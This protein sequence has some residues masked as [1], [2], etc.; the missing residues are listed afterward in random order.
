MSVRTV[1]LTLLPTPEQAV[2][3][4]RVGADWV[5]ACNLLSAVAWD[6]KTFRPYDLQK[7]AYYRV[8]SETGLLAQLTVRAV[9]V[10][11]DSYRRDRTRRHVFHARAALVLDTPRLYRLRGNVTEISTPDGRLTIRTAVGA[12][13]RGRLDEAEKLAEADL[14]RDRQGR[15][16]LLVSCHFADPPEQECSRFLGVDM[17]IANIAS[18]S[19]GAH[20]SGARRNELRRRHQRL[21]SRLQAKGTKGAKR[22][23]RK[24]ALKQRRFQSNENHCIAKS[25]VGCAKGTGRGIAIEQL[26]GIRARVS[27]RGADQRSALGNWAFAQLGQFLKYKARAAGV[28]VVEVDPH[29]TSQTCPCCGCVDPANRRSRSE[30]CCVTCGHAAHADTNAAIVIGSRAAV[31]QP[32]VGE[33]CQRVEAPP[34]SRLLQQAVHDAR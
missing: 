12:R 17:G 28:P 25:I 15:W 6:T 33:R 19:D 13:Q 7:I 11:C 16:R 24:R 26:A 5:R 4:G 32:H 31:M 14:I 2:S 20:F 3:L 9:K 21:R 10:V 30:F 1:A 22:L 34:T 29:H 18:T 23:L 27:A 8:R